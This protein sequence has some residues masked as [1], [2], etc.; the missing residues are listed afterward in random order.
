MSSK[1]KRSRSNSNKKGVFSPS[2]KIDD[3]EVPKQSKGRGAKRSGTAR[4]DH[5]AWLQKREARNA[6][7]AQRVRMR[8][9]HIQKQISSATEKKQ[10]A[11]LYCDLAN[12]HRKLGNEDEMQSSYEK[13]LEEDER[14]EE[15]RR[16]LVLSY[17]DAADA[18]QARLICEKYSNDVGATFMWTRAL[19]EH[20]SFYVLN[21]K[22]SSESLASDVLNRA[23][24]A[25]PFVAII[26]SYSSEF[27][28]NLK[29]EQIDLVLEDR[30]QRK[31]EKKSEVKEDT[32]EIRAAEAFEYCLT[33]V[34]C[35]LDAPEGI[36]RVFEKVDMSFLKKQ[37]NEC[38]QILKKKRIDMPCLSLFVKGFRSV[39]MGGEEEEEEENVV[40]E[41]LPQRK[42]QKTKTKKKRDRR[43][44]SG[45]K[46][47][48]NRKG[49]VYGGNSNDIAVYIN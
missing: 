16:G 1:R 31:K 2:G 26:L 8:F 23:V 49:C 39:M 7:I 22:D 38:D 40:E 35:W 13:A 29:S 11:V 47:S 14:C 5:L 24:K 42:K 17:M 20:L 25:N 6:L 27:L 30:R 28:S 34:S 32:W 46:R 33:G 44:R 48:R 43:A 4:S 18:A 45:Y 3:S 15:A 36:D 21:E 37:K 19:L 41:E 9:K 10:K 12:M